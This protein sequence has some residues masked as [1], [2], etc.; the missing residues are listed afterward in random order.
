L[1]ER[2]GFIHE[3]I[4]IKVLILYVL[5]R[6]PKPIS[7]DTLAELTICDDGISFFDFAECVAELTQS[8][9]IA[10]S[11][12]GYFITEKGRINGQATES[13]LPYSIRVKVDK[14]TSDVANA[15]KRSALIRTSH[16]TN[17]N[18]DVSVSLSMSD[19]V[20]PVISLQILAGNQQQAMQFEREFQKNAE[21]VYQKIVDALSGNE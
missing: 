1:E 6:V 12:V 8:E 15:Q 19:G 21:N 18:G 10:E 17:R 7:F 13:S 11:E 20:G 16:S 2:F 3:K 14:S 4:E 5:S 9:H